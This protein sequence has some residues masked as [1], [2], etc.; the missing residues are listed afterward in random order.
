MADRIA[1]AK[2]DAF[3]ANG[4]HE[5]AIAEYQSFL[6]RFPGSSLRADAEFELAKAYE[7]A[8]HTE[9]A[10]SSFWK[11]GE[12]EPPHPRGEEA[13]LKAGL[14]LTQHEEYE[15]AQSAYDQL[16]ASSNN[17]AITGKA[18]YEKGRAYLLSGDNTEAQRQFE[19]TVKEYQG[20][21][22]A[23]RA[24]I[25][26]GMVDL[27][28]GN[29]VAARERFN[30]I[31]RK[32]T[33]DVGAEAQYQIGVSFAR[34]EEYREA[35]TQLLRVRYVYPAATDWI[36]LS[37]LS[38]GECYEKLSETDKAREAYEMVLNTHKKDVMG[39]RAGERLKGIK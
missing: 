3:I 26:L 15:K 39:K 38:L 16:L 5:E 19:Q 6:A 13:L 4:S 12:A 9:K 33:D 25:G 17:A 35:V 14:L 31:V 24:V 37:Y 23:D 34:E 36:A 20:T 7:A 32:R 8:G 21:A 2:A 22:E 11:L 30:E 1:L 27:E 18:H 28:R 10:I 29:V